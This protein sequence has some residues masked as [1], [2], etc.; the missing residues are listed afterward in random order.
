MKKNIAIIGS[1]ISGLSSAFLLSNNH[2]ITLFEKNNY[3]GGH[4]RTITIRDNNKNLDIDTGFIVFNRKCYPDLTNFFKT[5]NVLSHDSNMSL[6]ICDKKSNLEYASHNFLFQKKNF[7]KLDYI[8]II[9]DIIRFYKYAKFILK[10]KDIDKLT[11]QHYFDNSGF[12]SDFINLH[13]YPIVSSIW[14]NDIKYIKDFPLKI[15]IEFFIDNNLFNLLSRPKWKTLV[16]K[17]K[18]YVDKVLEN[19][20]I[21]KY[22]NTEIINIE[23]GDSNIILYTKD[24]KYT[25]DEVIIS[26]H[27]D[28][29][30]ALIKDPSYYEYQLLRVFKY[31]KSEIF[32]HNDFKLMPENKKIWSSWNFIGQKNNKFCLSY[33]MNSLQKLN[34]KNNFIVTVN[35]LIEISKNNIY[36]SGKI[37]HPILNLETS[38]AQE[39]LFEIQGK[40]K[41]WFSGS[42]FGYGH[43]EDGI[44]SSIS[45]AKK[46]NIS[47]PW[48]RNNLDNRIPILFKNYD[49]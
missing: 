19:K 28:Q 39:K 42:Y 14:S 16:N 5:I 21:L 29:A 4:T 20:K 24:T 31:N 34:T 45:I 15:F 36:N 30:L 22:L 37:R 23:R 44:Q 46:M 48:I 11:L 7:L 13:I 35:P 1:G 41:I 17:G 9:L 27:A 43:H 3:F 32:L 8:K 18:S 10:R 26:T 33:W 6:T 47:I 38:K 12:S 25:F 2:N 40:N 49:L